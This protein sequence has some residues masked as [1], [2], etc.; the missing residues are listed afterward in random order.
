MMTRTMIE[1]IVCSK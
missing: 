1:D